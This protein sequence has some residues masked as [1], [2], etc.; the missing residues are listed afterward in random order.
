MFE[1]R[2]GD[3]MNRSG[4]QA[5]REESVDLP[6]GT[7][8]RVSKLSMDPLPN[9]VYLNIEESSDVGTLCRHDTG[10]CGAWG[11][12]GGAR[13]FTLALRRSSIPQVIELLQ[14]LVEVEDADDPG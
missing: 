1:E 9:I 10:F 11:T 5:I 13:N 2:D 3:V 12:K 4:E 14:S 8:I 7:R 6:C